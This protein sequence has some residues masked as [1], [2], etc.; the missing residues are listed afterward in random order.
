[1]FLEVNKNFV[2]E[3]IK[4]ID[5]VIKEYKLLEKIK[6]YLVSSITSGLTVKQTIE[7][8]DELAQVPKEITSGLINKYKISKLL[9]LKTDTKE[10][11]DGLKIEKENL[12]NI[13]E[14]TI[15][16]Y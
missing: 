4:Q 3:N 11:E 9:E 13:D 15:N 2:K 16:Q 8:I 7:V 6:P 5:A 10:L 14:R 1:M 12:K